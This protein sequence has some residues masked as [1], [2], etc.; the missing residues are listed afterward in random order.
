MKIKFVS[1]LLFLLFLQSCSDNSVGYK[2]S[3]EN[4]LLENLND[5]ESYEPIEFEVLDA[6]YLKY[7]NLYFSNYA[8]AIQRRADL[9]NMLRKHLKE[10][11]ENRKF[12]EFYSLNDSIT[13]KIISLWKLKEIK[14]LDDEILQIFQNINENENNSGYNYLAIISQIKGA[15]KVIYSTENRLKEFLDANCLSENP[16]EKIQMGLLV[17]HKYR[18]KNAFGAKI[19]NERLF[20]LNTDKSS[21]VKS[22]EIK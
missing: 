4:W 20:E 14:E 15:N 10:E 17:K 5:P 12:N 22:C 21:V 11:K 2:N 18:A 19:I 3:I 7:G 1:L 13:E 6:S 8:T 16:I 9:S